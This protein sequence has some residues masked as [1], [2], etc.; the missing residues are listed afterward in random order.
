MKVFDKEHN[1]EQNVIIDFDSGLV[2]RYKITDKLIK[3]QLGRRKSGGGFWERMLIGSKEEPTHIFTIR[4][5]LKT[6]SIQ[7][8]TS[9][10]DVTSN[11]RVFS[12]MLVGVNDFKELTEG[13]LI[14]LALGLENFY[15]HTVYGQ[16][17]GYFIYKDLEEKFDYGKYVKIQRRF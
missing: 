15:N 9:I 8:F 3:L 17:K 14:N 10:L 11:S 6:H 7:K 16:H 5:S 13:H 2:L 1:T 12:E 4:H